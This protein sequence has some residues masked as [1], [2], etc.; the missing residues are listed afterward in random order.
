MTNDKRRRY[1]LVIIAFCL[2]AG[3]LLG[4]LVIDRYRTDVH[5]KV[6]EIINKVVMIDVPPMDR[7]IGKYLA[8]N[9]YPYKYITAIDTFDN[10]YGI[11]E[12]RD[13]EVAA[14]A[15][16]KCVSTGEAI[17]G[18]YE[19]E[20][21]K[22]HIDYH[23]TRYWRV[24]DLR[25]T[26]GIGTEDEGEVTLSVTS[27]GYE[28]DDAPI[29]KKD[30]AGFGNVMIDSEVMLT[31]YDNSEPGIILLVINSGKRSEENNGN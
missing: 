17:P 18:V 23:D 8:K 16:G 10:T 20:G 15:H 11:Y 28:I 31:V 30:S 6:E 3:M 27:S 2:V 19:I 1:D 7:E 21:T 5:E 9:D 22:S 14:Y 25:S 29:I 24:V 13:N 12:V 4:R 26:K